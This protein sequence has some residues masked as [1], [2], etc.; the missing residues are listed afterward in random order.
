[1]NDI[2]MIPNLV[3][4][5]KVHIKKGDSISEFISLHYGYKYASHKNKDKEHKELPFHSDTNSLYKVNF[6]DIN[7][8]IVDITNEFVAENKNFIYIETFLNISPHSIFQP[9]KIA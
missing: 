1:M 2:L 8:K 7:L 4:H 9:P 6:I 5:L 3:Q